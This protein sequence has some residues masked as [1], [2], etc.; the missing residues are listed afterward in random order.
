M[1]TEL[2]GSN[3]KHKHLY[4]L[5]MKKYYLLSLVAAS[6]MGATCIQCTSPKQ[7]SGENAL[8][9][10]SELFAKLPDCCPTPDGMAIAPNGDL[11]LACPNFADITQPACLMR[12]TKNGE[13]AKWMDVPVLEETGWASPMGIAFNEEGDLFICDNQGW[14]GA[15]KAQNK[16][17]VLRLKF[18][19]DQLKRNNHCGIR[20]GAS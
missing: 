4:Y 19:N 17:R 18:E 13:I 1:R 7:K 14:S 8:P 6:L 11:I 15:E 5:T 2:T 12:I 3:Y 16:G 9:Q 10:K 20:Y